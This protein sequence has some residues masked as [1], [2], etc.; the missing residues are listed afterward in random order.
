M[1][2][3]TSPIAGMPV[4]EVWRA[5]MV[6]VNKRGKGKGYAAIENPLFFNENTRMFYGNAADKIKEI[7]MALEQV[8]NTI[9]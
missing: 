9:L 7:H 1:E 5:N 2:N 8:I 3:P 6:F 4:C